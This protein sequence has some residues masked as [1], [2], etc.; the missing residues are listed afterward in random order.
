MTSKK[1]NYFNFSHK[2]SGDFDIY[3]MKL[4]IDGLSVNLRN[5]SN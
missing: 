4:S 5:L 1:I 3:P 2:L